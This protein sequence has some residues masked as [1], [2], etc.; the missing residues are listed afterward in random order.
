MLWDAKT[1]TCFW[2]LFTPRFARREQISRKLTR[3][4]RTGISIAPGGNSITVSNTGVTSV[5]LSAPSAEF[6]VN[7][8]PV[9]TTGTLTLT[10]QTQVANSIWAGPVMGP[11]AQPAFRFLDILDL[12]G[13][14]AGQ[15]FI[16][17][18]T[19]VTAAFLTAGTGINIA[20]AS[21]SITVSNTG[22]TNVALALPGSVFSVSGSPVTTAGTLT[23][24]FV[25][26]AANTIFAGPTTG[27]PAT[28][29]FRS[30]VLAD[31][32]HLTNGQ[33][34]IG[35]TGNSVAAAGITAGSAAIS[36]TNGAGSITLDANINIAL[37]M[38]SIFSVAGSPVLN[39]GTFTVSLATQTQRTVFAGPASGSPAAP[40]FRALDVVDLPPLLNGQLYI[41]NAGTPTV[42]SLSAGA[43]KKQKKNH[44]E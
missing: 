37:S 11:A 16:G 22:V 12:P 31:L 4:E 21:G 9:T 42:S 26:Q 44:S 35:S 10:K 27:S 43:G 8:S 2:C 5:A 19:A 1:H 40:T 36:V 14:P 18:G 34:Y 24:S 28:P 3:R 38:P 29:S 13:I 32:P 17:T 25:N 41:G 33:L 23:G 6:I 30:Q 15:V 20:S 39:S 7:G